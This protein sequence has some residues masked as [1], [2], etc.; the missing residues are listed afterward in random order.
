MCWND[1]FY[2]CIRGK[3]T[4]YCYLASAILDLGSNFIIVMILDTGLIGGN[5][6]A[7]PSQKQC[8]HD[9]NGTHKYGKDEQGNKYQWIIG[10]KVLKFCYSHDIAFTMANF[11]NPTAATQ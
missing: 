1:A 2:T 8:Y 11:T 7:L 4:Q 5:Q 9:G 6:I 3:K 10:I